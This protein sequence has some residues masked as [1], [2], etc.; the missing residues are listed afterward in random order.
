MLGLLGLAV[1]SGLW[2]DKYFD[3][4]FPVFLIAL[5]LLVI[6]STLVLIVKKI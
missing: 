5:P 6:I 3:F 2:L 1:I 4:H